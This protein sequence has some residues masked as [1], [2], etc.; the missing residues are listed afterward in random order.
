MKLQQ[1]IDNNKEFEEILILNH[2]EFHEHFASISEMFDKDVKL[3]KSIWDGK[4]FT[5]KFEIND[6]IYT[7]KAME[8]DKNEYS[9]LFYSFG[10]NLFDVKGDKTYTGE[11]FSA[12]KKSLHLLINSRDVDM[13]W[14]NTNEPKLIK[15]YDK[16]LKKMEK[17]FK[18][19]E[20]DRSLMKGK[21]KFWRFKRK[22]II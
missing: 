22:R 16:L 9:I 19:F 12:I 2:K 10:K 4:Y 1:Y 15:L 17:E 20:Y 8:N 5:V 3:E 14:F 7:F 18:D 21:H 6:D 13:F 11:V